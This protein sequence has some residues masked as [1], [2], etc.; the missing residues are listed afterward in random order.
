MQN[1]TVELLNCGK[2]ANKGI[3]NG[4]CGLDQNTLVPL[5]NTH[6]LS[7]SK[8]PNFLSYHQVIIK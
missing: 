8:L 6:S 2:P 4:Y 5:I 7:F 3:N 1:L